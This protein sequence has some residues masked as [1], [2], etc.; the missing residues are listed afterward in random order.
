MNKKNK[1]LVI[2]L[3]IIILLGIIGAILL[4][5]TDQEIVVCNQKGNYN[6]P[7]VKETKYKI[8]NNK[9]LKAFN[10]LFDMKLEAN[11]DKNILLTHTIFVY[12]E[13]AASSNLIDVSLEKNKVEFNIDSKS[14]QK[15]IGEVYTPNNLIAI[16]PNNKLLFVNTSEWKSPI[17]VKEQNE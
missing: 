14:P 15:W 13:Y 11:F 9:E 17:K 5:N 3:V 10:S 2:I 8:R 1:V 6:G 16:I 7:A 12:R 4:L